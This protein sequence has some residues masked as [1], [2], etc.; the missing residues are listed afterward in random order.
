MNAPTELTHL[1]PHIQPREVPAELMSALQARFGA[2]CSTALA[3]REQHG[4]D[5]SVYDVP[6][7][8]AVVFAQSTQDVADAVKLAALYKVPVIPFG[9]GSSLEG[10]LLAVQGGISIDVG[11]MNAVLSINA[12]D[13][14]V[15]VQP[16]VTRK[17]VNEAVKSEGLF[18]PIDP[19]ADASIGG[20]AATRASGTNAVRYGTMREN[21]LA[22]EVVTASGEVIRTGTRAKKSSAGYDLTRLMVGSEGTLG[23]MTEVTLKLYPLP[24]AISA[25]TC[26]FPSIEAAVRTTIQVIQMGI[27]IARCELIDAGTVRMV[28]AHSKLGLRE[29]HMLLMEFHG[30]PASVKEQA[31]TVQEIASEFGANSENGAFEWATTP[32]ERTRLWTARHNAYFAAIQ[33][34]PGCRAVSTDTC[35]PISRLADCLLDSVAEADASGIPYFLV[36]HVGDGNFHFGYLIDP[37]KPEEREQ[38]EVLNHQLVARA[39]R[40]EGTCTGEHGVG[41]HKMDFLLTEAGSGAVDMM[42]TIK[43]AL[44]P[45]NI[46]NP[47]KIF[48]L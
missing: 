38:A 36:G 6:P 29:E 24:E 3:V 21:V 26:S 9:V 48:A 7:P 45:H 47:G 33:S 39:L 8:A 25:A 41:L 5:E 20:M 2:Q 37:T 16:G 32:E 46:L 19:G 30:S 31:E 12:E 10:H 17:A 23:I 34:K 14:T 4:R 11:R 18:F 35:V 43:R 42:R 22:L 15:T 27:P 44:D 1:V 40:L 13:L 28:N